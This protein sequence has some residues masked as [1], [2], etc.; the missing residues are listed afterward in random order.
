M[1]YP[2]E[3]QKTLMKNHVTTGIAFAES[4]MSEL[5]PQ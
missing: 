4:D 3:A 1:L 5:P 2:A